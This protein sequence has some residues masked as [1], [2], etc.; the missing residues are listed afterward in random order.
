MT[1]TVVI[2]AES[3]NRAQL[4]VFAWDNVGLG[5]CAGVCIDWRGSRVAAKM[6]FKGIIALTSF[7]V[8]LQFIY[9]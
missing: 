6:S 2:V 5:V 3:K 9:F 8:N 7:I 1:R 4:T